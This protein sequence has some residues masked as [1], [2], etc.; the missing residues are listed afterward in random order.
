MATSMSARALRSPASRIVAALAATL[1]ALAPW[2]S[3]A[4][5]EDAPA[6]AVVCQ[7]GSLSRQRTE[8]D[9]DIPVAGFDAALGTLLEVN[10][11]TQAVHLDTDAL[12]ENTAQT[13][14]TFEEHMTYQVTFSSPGGL[15]SPPPVAGTIERVPTQTIAAF[16]GTLDFAGAS[17]VAQPSTAR[18]AEAAPVSS[19]DPVVLTAFTGGTVAFHVATSIG[20]TFM[21]GGGNIEF[22]INT[23]GSASV[24]VC[25][26]YAPP[27]PPPTTTPPTTTPPTT[28]AATTPP[29]TVPVRVA[30]TSARV[31]AART[32]PATG[33]PDGLLAGLGTGAVVLGAVLVARTRRARSGFDVGAI[34]R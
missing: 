2:I 23:F 25:Y 10:V 20:E 12:F 4:A 3:P 18:D 1:V 11:A 30:S 31:P 16:D 22:K 21:G 7:D 13:A 34:D 14:V 5:A 15:A 6:E 24:Q 33:A 17:S 19:T 28:T 32:L 8:I 27:A 9:A 26:R 29:T